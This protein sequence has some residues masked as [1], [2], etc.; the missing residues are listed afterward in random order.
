MFALVYSG[1]R[2]ES[3]AKPISIKPEEAVARSY[4]DRLILEKLSE[5]EAA[6]KLGELADKLSGVGIGLAAVRSLMAS[7]PDV[8]AYH[9]RRWVPAARLNSQG[10][11]IAE[12]MRA[13]LDSF[14]APVQI[15]T[16]IDEVARAQRSTPEIM[17][18]TI[19]RLIAGNGGFVEVEGG[20]VGLDAWGFVAT[21]EKFDR[22]LEINR[23][24]REDFEA[25][26]TK[27]SDVDFRSPNWAA[28]VLKHAPIKLKEAGAVAHSKLNNDDPRSV[29]MYS[30]GEILK[31]LFAEPNFVYNSDGTFMTEADAKG[32]VSTALKVAMKLTPS[33]DID[34]VAPIEFKSDD[35]AKLI[36][37]I[38]ASDKT[39]T[40]IKLLEEHFEITPGSKTYPDDLANIIATL[41]ASKEVEWIG[42][43]RFRKAG[44]HPEYIMEVPEPFQFV[45]TGMLDEEGEEIDVELT[46]DG[47]NSSLRKLLQH[48]LALDV[49]DE[50]IQPA[51]KSQPESIRLVL[52]QFTENS[53]PSRLLSFQ[54]DGSK[55]N[56]RFKKR[57]LSILRV[58][59]FKFGLT[60]KLA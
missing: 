43:D 9:E 37:K 48:P 2:S 7:N 22:A 38:V 56:R 1:I 54:L 53:A 28:Q 32:L 4:A 46:D 47:L 18:P 13:I 42:G 15:T 20:L 35:I 40:A 26:A 59:N 12:I 30:S 8:F 10:R 52:N 51:L 29:L 55:T 34:D 5:M 57:F 39:T 33:I 3:L 6:V 24:S 31:G 19:L 27:L 49:V 17:E 11:P 23:I 14:G 25:A 21:D 44:D 58:E 16:L 60:M 41:C 36:K 50:D 45:A